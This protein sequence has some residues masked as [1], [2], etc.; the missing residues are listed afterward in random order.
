MPWHLFLL[1]QQLHQQL[2]LLTLSDLLAPL[3]SRMVGLTPQSPQSPVVLPPSPPLPLHPHTLRLCHLPLRSLL[4]QSSTRRASQ[5]QSCS[6]VLLN[7][8]LPPPLKQLR[9]PHV[10]P[11]YLPKAVRVSHTRLLSRRVLSARA[12]TVILPL[13]GPLSTRV[14]WQMAKIIAS[15]SV[16][17]RKLVLAVPVLVPRLRLCLVRDWHRIPIRL[18]V[19]RPLVYPHLPPCGIR[20]TCVLLHLFDDVSSFDMSVWCV[21]SLVSAIRVWCTPRPI[22]S[23]IMA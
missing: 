22:L 14:P 9:P 11:L 7:P 13:L 8:H 12:K 2:N 21:H 15:V 3:P 18:L 20:T 19:A 10:P 5:S 17:G 23:T 4:S 6:K 1:H 16:G